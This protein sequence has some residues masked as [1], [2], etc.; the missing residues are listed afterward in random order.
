MK[1]LFQSNVIHFR[2]LTLDGELQTNPSIQLIDYPK[3]DQSED[4]NGS[5]QEDVVSVE[6]EENEL[7]QQVIDEESRRKRVLLSTLSR[8]KKDFSHAKQ[9]A[10]EI[11][12]ATKNVE[13]YVDEPTSFERKSCVSST[14]KKS[15]RKLPYNV[16]SSKIQD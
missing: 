14:P 16:G 10:R 11:L 2:H 6:N 3:T 7:I 4:P 5:G 12:K 1:K 13:D 8:L 9:V 15:V